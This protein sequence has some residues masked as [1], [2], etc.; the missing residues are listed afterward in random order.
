MRMEIN[1]L[2]FFNGSHGDHDPFPNG[3]EI[4]VPILVQNEIDFP[5]MASFFFL[6]NP[7]VEHQLCDVILINS[8]DCRED[9]IV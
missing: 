4:R 6:N 5:L 9:N 1:H 8:T 2:H 7:T 3:D